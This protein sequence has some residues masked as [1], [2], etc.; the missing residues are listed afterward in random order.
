MTS[1]GTSTS[2]LEEGLLSALQAQACWPDLRLQVLPDKGLAHAHVRLLGTGALA[3]IPK[4]SQLGLDPRANLRHQAACFERAAHSGHTPRLFGMLPVSGSLPRGA[5]LVEEIAGTPASLPSDLPAI[6]AALGALHA[7][8]VPP[9]SGR[10]PLASPLDPLRMLLEEIGV[11]AAHVPDARLGR[12]ELRLL[13]EELLELRRLPTRPDRPGV[14]LI[15]FDAHPGNFIVRADGQAVLVDLEKC[16]YS[17]PGLDLAHATLYTSTTWDVATSAILTLPE[18]VGF[19]RAWEDAM[20]LAIGAAARPWH[21]GLRRAMWLWSITWCCKWRVLSGRPPQSP[22]AGEDWS[23]A[24]S[25]PELVAHVRERVD[26][27]LSLPAILRVREE[28]EALEEALE[29]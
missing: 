17:Y 16:R 22:Q 3:R 24:R 18:V 6:A 20:G 26:H 5:L 1:S 23:G 29:K 7:V 15:A 2:R 9:E 19:Y 21:V 27:Y 11:Q 4:Q 25:D 12:A 10:A 28:L 13:E 14:H 8:P